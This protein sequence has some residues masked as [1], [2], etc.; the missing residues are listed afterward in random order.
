MGWGWF[1]DRTPSGQAGPLTSHTLLKGPDW[2]QRSGQ[3]L[4]W[5]CD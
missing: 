5:L 1:D 3:G 4:R 2:L